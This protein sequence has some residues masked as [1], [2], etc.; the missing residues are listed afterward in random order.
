MKHLIRTR[1]AN[2]IICEVAFPARQQGRVALVCPGA[3]GS[4]F[5][6]EVL[7]FLASKGYVAILMRYRGT[8]ESGG[9]FLEHPPTK[10]VTDIIDYLVKKKSIVDAWN[11]EK[12]A[13]K[14]KYIDLFGASFGGPAVL[15]NSKHPKVRKVIAL[16]PVIDWRNCGAGE[17]FESY[18]Q[19]SEVGFGGAYRVKNKRDWN[20]FLQK[21]FYN[22]ITMLDKINPKKCF[23]I[24]TLDDDSC[25]VENVEA[26]EKLLPISIY[27]KQKGGH[28]GVRYIL[29]KFYWRKTEAFLRKK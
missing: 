16:A 29:H 21:D 17:T 20:K 13:I 19:F 7:T 23:I 11:N 18:V 5:K 6:N 12:I 2:D 1:I 22:P 24:Q 10:D 4:P 3:P 14:I 27:Y 15:L 25:P 9:T 26:L 8:W 28:L